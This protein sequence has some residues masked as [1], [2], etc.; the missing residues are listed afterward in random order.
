M[1]GLHTHVHICP[2]HIDVYTHTCKH[3]HTYK[4]NKKTISKM[5][6]LNPSITIITLNVNGVN[7]FKRLRPKH[8]ID[9]IYIEFMYYYPMLM[10]IIVFQAG[11]LFRL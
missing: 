1:S 9:L 5:M 2:R 8:Y 3:G 4:K 10:F 6:D 11:D 7:L